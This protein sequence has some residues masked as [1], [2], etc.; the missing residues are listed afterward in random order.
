MSAFVP[1]PG[2]QKKYPLQERP[3]GDFVIDEHYHAIH[4]SSGGDYGRH[5]CPIWLE[6]GLD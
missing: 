3:G 1:V 4:V 5:I 6:A 2:G